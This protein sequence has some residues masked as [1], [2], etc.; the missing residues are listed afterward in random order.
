[1]FLLINNEDL[2]KVNKRI[3]FNITNDG[4]LN[5]LM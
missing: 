2:H 3:I 5:L 4:N 1:M